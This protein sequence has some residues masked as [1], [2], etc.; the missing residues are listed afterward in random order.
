MTKLPAF[1]SRLRRRRTHAVIGEIE[2]PGL[3]LDSR[4]RFAPAPS[5]DTTEG[6][7]EP[8]AMTRRKAAEAATQTTSDPTDSPA[9]PA[10]T[11]PDPKGRELYERQQASE[12]RIRQLEQE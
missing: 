6:K 12:Q 1:L 9:A 8:D 7:G 4:V 11:S 3:S 10:P 2:T 5:A